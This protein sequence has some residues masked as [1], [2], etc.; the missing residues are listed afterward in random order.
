MKKTTIIT[1]IIVIIV[2]IVLLT[3]SIFLLKKKAGVGPETESEEGALGA[4]LYRGMNQ[5]DSFTMPETNPFKVETN[6]I[7]RIKINPFE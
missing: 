7:K 2:V 4:F 3:G 5:Q 6:P 1:I